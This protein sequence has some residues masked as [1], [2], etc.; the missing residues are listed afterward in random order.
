MERVRVRN[1]NR[2]SHAV[3]VTRNIP[4]LS[5]T[6]VTLSTALSCHM[7]GVGKEVVRGYTAVGIFGFTSRLNPRPV[8]MLVSLFVSQRIF[9]VHLN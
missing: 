3:L 7:L 8:A 6:K 1:F 4:S 2:C 5:T 9:K